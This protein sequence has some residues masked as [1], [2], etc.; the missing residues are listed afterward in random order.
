[1]NRRQFLAGLMASTAALATPAL[2]GELASLYRDIKAMCDALE[3]QG[4][5]PRY[6]VMSPRAYLALVDTPV[7]PNCRIMG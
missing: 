5:S 2:D 6:V 7:D 4:S 1:M 3:R